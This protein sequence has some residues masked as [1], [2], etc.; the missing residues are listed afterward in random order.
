MLTIVPE[1]VAFER[2]L[3]SEY[4]TIY[5]YRE[6]F[7]M[8]MVQEDML[9]AIRDRARNESAEQGRIS[10]SPEILEKIEDFRHLIFDE[11]A[12]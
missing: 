7:Q 11:E 9:G 3:T 4:M 8:G 2:G 5:T 12:V 10:M 1:E 6:D